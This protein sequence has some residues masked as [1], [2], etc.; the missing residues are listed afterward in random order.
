MR[1]SLQIDSPSASPGAMLNGSNLTAKPLPVWTSNR[2][3]QQS[4]LQN[5]ARMH[6]PRTRERVLLHS[7]AVQEHALLVA[8]R[9]EVARLALVTEQEF[10]L[11]G[12]AVKC[13]GGWG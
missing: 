8:A 7:F 5:I 1:W 2:K 6:Q 13:N 4:G 9:K 3:W 10:V 12:V 11:E